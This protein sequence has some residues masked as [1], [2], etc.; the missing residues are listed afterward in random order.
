[1]L[2]SLNKRG[3]ATVVSLIFMALLA[4]LAAGFGALVSS[5]IQISKNEQAIARA[6]AAAE[7]GMEVMKSCLTQV[8]VPAA[9][10]AT[11][12]FDINPNPSSLTVTVVSNLVS[13]QLRDA[14][15]ITAVF[16]S[17]VSSGRATSLVFPS[18]TPQTYFRLHPGK[19]DGFYATITPMDNSVN[20]P[21]ISATNCKMLHIAVIGTDGQQGVTRQVN[22][23]FNFT[24]GTAGSAWAG[25][26]DTVFSEGRITLSGGTSVTDDPNNV[27]STLKTF[28][29]TNADGTTTDGACLRSALPSGT[30]ISI[31]GGAKVAG[32]LYVATS[33]SQVSYDS[34][35]F[36]V[37]GT[38]FVNGWTA[39]QKTAF[40]NANFD[41]ATPPTPP[42]FDS[43]VFKALATTTWDGTP[44]GTFTN[45]RIPA[46][47]NF[48]ANSWG[49]SDTLTFKGIVYIES[50]NQIN[51]N[52]ACNKATFVFANK[53][54]DGTP[55]TPGSDKLTFSGDS[56]YSPLDPNDQSLA[57]VRTALRGYSILAPTAMID[58]GGSGSTSQY[59]GNLIAWTLN[60]HG[61][62]AF[63]I[64]DGSVITYSPSTSACILTGSSGFDFKRSANYVIPPNGMTDTGEGGA[65]RPGYF[66]SNLTSY[67]EGA[68]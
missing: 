29:V 17:P 54:N 1:M 41:V 3:S 51:L 28:T 5:S 38:T 25:W 33:T 13:R 21:I 62:Q 49:G 50:P 40:V 30:A 22:F 23:D 10:A 35:Q 16:D 64:V 32:Q 31:S 27:T 6:Q 14:A 24:A 15:K 42:V 11:D 63:Q 53:K 7:S 66:T 18:T 48:N 68:H 57:T 4:A 26:N 36:S 34:S 8:S 19:T 65:A 9:T 20:P 67:S 55:V 37:N 44:H 39:A 58:C 46:N 56:K 47:S 59:V 12:V 61:N 60:M 43:T 52:S 45:V 2:S